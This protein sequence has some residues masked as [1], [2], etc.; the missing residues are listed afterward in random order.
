MNSLELSIEINGRKDIENLKNINLDE[1]EDLYLYIY[2]PISL[3]FLKKFNNLKKLLI[4]GHVKD[5]TP[6][7]SCKYLE[8]LHISTS[9]AIDNLDFIKNLSIK[10]LEL[11]SFRTKNKDFYIPNIKTLEIL[12]ISSVSAIINLEF[13]SDF[14]SLKNITLFQ[15]QSKIMFDCTK[16]EQLETL[17]L[18][19]MFH[20]RDFQELKTIQKLENLT[21][22]QFYINRIIKTD[23]KSEL[24][25]IISD[26]KK[27]TTIKLIINDQ[28]LYK[29]DLLKIKY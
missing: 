3:S 9:G 5:Y 19:N 15:L 14:T 13:L 24:V 10:T 4:G 29:D 17:R 1:I 23:P 22:H 18:I 27:I 20:L 25:K 26:L 8:F 11:E 7:T 2:T 21:I 12:N 16:L 6:V 28:I